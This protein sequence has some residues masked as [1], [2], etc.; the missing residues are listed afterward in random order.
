MLEAVLAS[1]VDL[2]MRQAT[3]DSLSRATLRGLSLEQQFQGPMVVARDPQWM[4]GVVHRLS[5][6]VRSPRERITR[7]RPVVMAAIRVLESF[8]EIRGKL[9]R[10]SLRWTRVARAAPARD[11][12]ALLRLM[13]V[14][15]SSQGFAARFGESPAVQDAAHRLRSVW[16]LP[17]LTHE[18]W[19]DV[20]G[21][22][23]ADWVPWRPRGPPASSLRTFRQD[24][25]R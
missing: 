25:I 15:R 8:I 10:L 9:N 11:R 20:P 23:S 22:L 3:Q 12:A 2:A 21:D 6:P 14:A 18:S 1:D 13:T 7:P 17:P 5:P 16:V 4:K 19:Y 24:T